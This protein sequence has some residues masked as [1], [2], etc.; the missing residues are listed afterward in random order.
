MS[1]NRECAT[2]SASGTSGDPIV[3]ERL[4]I[5]IGAEPVYA[6]SLADGFAQQGEVMR[7][8]WF[9]QSCQ[10]VASGLQKALAGV[11]VCHPAGETPDEDLGALR[12]AW[13]DTPVLAWPMG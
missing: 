5:V 8:M 1:T 13:P 7:V 11:V 2:D 12:R 9:S 4:V 10:A 6:N 3:S